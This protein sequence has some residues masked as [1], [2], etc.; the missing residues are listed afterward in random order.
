MTDGDT[1]MQRFSKD[2]LENTRN[3]ITAVRDSLRSILSPTS[4]SLANM[5]IS[6]ILA[7]PPSYDPVTNEGSDI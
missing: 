2:D 4:Y 6:P 7:V 3:R 5:L 1:E